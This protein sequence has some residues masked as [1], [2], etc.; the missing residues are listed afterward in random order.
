MLQHLICKTVSMIDAYIDCYIFCSEL[1]V[2]LEAFSPTS[3]AIFAV[4]Y[5]LRK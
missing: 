3:C 1:T 2:T 4:W 5:L